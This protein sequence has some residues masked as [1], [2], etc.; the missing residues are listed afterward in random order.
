M[1]PFIFLLLALNWLHFSRSTNICNVDLLFSYGVTSPQY[2]TETP[3]LCLSSEQDTCCSNNDQSALLSLW[4]ERDKLYIK[5]YYMA[6]VWLTKGIFQ[7]Y[8]DIIVKAKYMHFDPEVSATCKDHANYLVRNYM[9]KQKIIDYVGEIKA[10]Y[11]YLGK[12][13]KGFYCS[14]CSV[15]NQKYFDVD[16][17]KIT[18][19]NGFCENLIDN[20]LTTISQ[21]LMTILPI[22]DKINKLLNCADNVSTED[23]V[24]ILPTPKIVESMGK[25]YRAVK[26]LKNPKLYLRQCLSFCSEFSMVEASELFEGMIPSMEYVFKKV[27][28]FGFRATDV[29]FPNFDHSQKFNFY[30]I[31]SLFHDHALSFQDLAKYE[32][33]FDKFGV[34]LDKD[35]DVSVY[36]YGASSDL[37]IY[38]SSWI[39]STLLA[40]LFL[41]F[42]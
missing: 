35:S 15:K 37:L 41:I 11:N 39:L 27:H 24:N 2:L 26:A 32:I 22:F 17:K 8:E 20:S 12:A 10:L 18:Y 6:M 34:D 40:L 9:P 4:N 21:R 42:L 23:K 31:K 3:M 29:A 38:E 7:Y 19:S 36:Y 1:K 33:L 13:R 14:M 5:P 30:S 25:C 16:T 28:S